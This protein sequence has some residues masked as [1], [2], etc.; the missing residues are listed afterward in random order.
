VAPAPR[1]IAAGHETIWA[2]DW[3]S[4]PGDEEILVRAHL[5]TIVTT[6]GDHLLVELD[7]SGITIRA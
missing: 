7:R 3:P 1:L 2:G 5:S 4:D 6:L